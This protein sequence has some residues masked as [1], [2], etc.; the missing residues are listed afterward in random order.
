M[1]NRVTSPWIDTFDNLLSQTSKSLLVCSPYVGQG[2]C[3]RLISILNRKGMLGVSFLLLTDLSRDNML[4]GATDVA[5]IAGLC[6][7]IPK[8]EIRFLPNLHAKVYVVDDRCAIVTSA[9]LTDAG[10]RRNFEYGLRIDDPDL[11]KE[12]AA[13]ISQYAA[14]GSIVALSQLRQF[15]AVIADLKLLKKEVEKR[16]KAR[17]RNEFERKMREAEAEIL[18]VRVEGLSS[19]AAFAD[20]ILFLLKKAPA[21][22][23]SLYTAVQNIHPD[24]CDDSIKLVIKGEEWSQ[25]KWHHRVRHAQLFLKRQGRIRREGDKWHF[26]R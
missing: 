10:L 12:V 11:V 3:E 15:E 4:S 6:E 22:T 17:L 13:D 8:A 24:L 19:H 7:A 20:T 5:A 21:N 14:L 16:L 25:V 26:V 1:I 23:K 18:R 2:P 9:N